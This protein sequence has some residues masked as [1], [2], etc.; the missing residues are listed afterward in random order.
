MNRWLRGKWACRLKNITQKFRIQ[1]DD[2]A[3]NVILKYIQQIPRYMPWN[4]NTALFYPLWFS[5]TIDLGQHWLRLWLVV[6]RHQAIIGTND[7]FSLMR[8]HLRAIPQRAPHL[9]FHIMIFKIILSKSLPLLP[10]TK[11]FK[12]KI[13]TKFCVFY[14][15]CFYIVM[16]V[17]GGYNS[18]MLHW[19]W[20]RDTLQWRHNGRDSVSNHQPHHCL[21]KSLFRRR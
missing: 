4:M 15:I 3:L 8:F 7:D 9:L 13:W 16:A 11:Q 14:F 18:R 10:G 17:R 19:R 2:S 5:N 6:W 20:D 21:L 1:I 12:D